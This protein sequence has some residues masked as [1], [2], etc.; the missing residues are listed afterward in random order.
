MPQRTCDEEESCKGATS[1]TRTKRDVCLNCCTRGRGGLEDLNRNF[2]HHLNVTQKGGLLLSQFS[3][4]VSV[5]FV[6]YLEVNHVTFHPL[7]A[8][9]RSRSVSWSHIS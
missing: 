3:Y 1:K 8:I 2:K 5:G 6:M 9:N 4:Q 7:Q